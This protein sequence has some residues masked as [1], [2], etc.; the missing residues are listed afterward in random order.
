MLKG[1]DGTEGANPSGSCCWHNMRIVLLTLQP[2]MMN[3]KC[4]M[5]CPDNGNRIGFTFFRALC[6][7]VIVLTLLAIELFSNF[8]TIGGNSPRLLDGNTMWIS[9][10][11]SATIKVGLN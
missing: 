4:L 11:V 7:L 5:D 6:M 3:L 8:I 9:Q 10:S 1:R 2:L